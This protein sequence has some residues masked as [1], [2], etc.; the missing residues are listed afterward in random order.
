MF[1]SY[2]DKLTDSAL[3]IIELLKDCGL[4]DFKNIIKNVYGRGQEYRFV[5]KEIDAPIDSCLFQTRPHLNRG[6][7]LKVLN[8]LKLVLIKDLQNSYFFFLKNHTNTIGSI[9]IALP[10]GDI[11]VRFSDEKVFD[12]YRRWL[13]YC[14]ENSWNFRKAWVDTRLTKERV[15]LFKALITDAGFD[16]KKYNGRIVSSNYR[17]FNCSKLGF[18]VTFYNWGIKF[19][20]GD[21]AQGIYHLLSLPQ[22]LSNYELYIEMLKFVIDECIESRL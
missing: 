2:D 1:N 20:Q 14:V 13:I 3:T 8:N 22:D 15:D 21:Q 9:D 12:L 10:L 17:T 11:A 18:K 4:E 6:Q 5:S 7:I 16:M 19:Y